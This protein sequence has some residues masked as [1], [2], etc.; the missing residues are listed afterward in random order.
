[1]EGA[2]L[3]VLQ[4]GHRALAEFH[5]SILLEIHGTQLHADC[6][7]FLTKLGYHLEEAYGQI[8]ATPAHKSHPST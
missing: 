2:E 6:R 5:P 4:G 1:M 7:A 8:V 3:E